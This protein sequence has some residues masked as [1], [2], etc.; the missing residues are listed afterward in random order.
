MFDHILAHDLPVDR[1]LTIFSHEPS[2]VLLECHNIVTLLKVGVPIGL[3][4]IDKQDDHAIGVNEL[5][6]A[7]M[8]DDALTFGATVVLSAVV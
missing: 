6:E 3:D 8:Q 2:L 1:V 4:L 7:Y 5:L